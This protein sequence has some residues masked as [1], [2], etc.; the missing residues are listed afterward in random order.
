MLGPRGYL[1]TNMLVSPMRNGRAGGL[2]Q[3]DSPMANG[4]ALQW[5]IGFKVMTPI[6]CNN[7]TQNKGMEICYVPMAS[8]NLVE[9]RF[10]ELYKT[11]WFLVSQ[12]SPP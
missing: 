5:N 6:W 4:F 11:V 12:T 3:C 7:V 2:N 10:F 1:N 8:F 9:Y